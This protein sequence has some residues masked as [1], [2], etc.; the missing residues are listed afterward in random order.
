MKA[1]MEEGPKASVEVVRDGFPRSCLN[2]KTLSGWQG[3]IPGDRNYKHE[4]TEAESTTSTGVV[5]GRAQ[6]KGI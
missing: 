1:P 5:L 6:D 4:G 2:L 3:G